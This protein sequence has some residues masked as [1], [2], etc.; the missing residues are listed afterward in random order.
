MRSIRAYFQEEAIMRALTLHRT[1]LLQIG[2]LFFLLAI[3]SGVGLASACTLE[4][5]ADNAG[6]GDLL[7]GDAAIGIRAYQGDC[8]LR[9]TLD[10]TDPHYLQDNNPD[11]EKRYIARFYLYIGGYMSTMDS[12]ELVLLSGYSADDTRHFGLI[13]AKNPSG[14]F[15]LSRRIRTD[16]GAE[17]TEAGGASLN[18][19]WNEIVLD[20]SASGIDGA[21]EGSLALTVNGVS[22]TAMDGID[23]DQAQ[24]DHVRLGV[25]GGLSG[26]TDSGQ[27]MIDTFLSLRSGDPDSIDPP[28]SDGDGRND[29][30]DPDDDNDSISDFTEEAIGLNPLDPDDALAD[31]D[32]DGFSNLVEAIAGSDLDD[33]GSVP[34][35][36]RYTDVPYDHA[37]WAGIELLVQNGIVSECASDRFCPGQLATRDLLA[38]WLAKALGLSAVGSPGNEFDDVAADLTNAGWIEALAAEGITEGCNADGSLYC[39]AEVVTRAS[40]AKLL[41]RAKYGY[42]YEPP[43]AGGALFS[44]VQPGDFAADFIEILFADGITDGCSPTDYCPSQ[45]VT[46]AELARLLVRTFSLLP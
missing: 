40:I 15:T 6:G 13:L 21:D 37:N 16:A 31:K 7:A 19:N 42:D 10:D 25:D 20:W 35:A 41:L 28:D 18:P 46:R 44:D 3:Q 9:V 26:I 32:G 2:T 27:F 24:I 36:S 43:V 45:P 38:V 14:D 29:N 12:A 22:Q 1:I 30:D 23:N 5:W 11:A 39:P 17:N 33:P 4:N 8:G 34:G